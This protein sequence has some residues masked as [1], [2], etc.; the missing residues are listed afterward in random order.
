MLQCEW[1]EQSL[2]C[3]WSSMWGLGQDVLRFYLTAPAPALDPSTCLIFPVGGKI[4]SQASYCLLLKFIWW[5]SQG[6][7]WLSSPPTK[8]LNAH[9]QSLSHSL[10]CNQ[11]SDMRASSETTCAS[12]C[13]LHRWHADSDCFEWLRIILINNTNQR[14]QGVHGLLRKPETAL[15]LSWTP[16]CMNCLLHFVHFWTEIHFIWCITLNWHNKAM[17]L[18]INSLLVEVD[19]IHFLL[20]Y[21]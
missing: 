6:W 16:I 5:L 13:V 10:P 2:H 12:C 17:S 20:N 9:I 21:L 15:Q 3:R 4:I 18:L 14:K 19:S 8:W 1:K 11:T 7:C